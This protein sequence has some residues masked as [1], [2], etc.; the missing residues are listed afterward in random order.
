MNTNMIFVSIVE[1]SPHLSF[2]LSFLLLSLRSRFL[3]SIEQDTQNDLLEL[4]NGF[5]PQDILDTVQTN[6]SRKGKQILT[7][8][9]NIK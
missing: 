7:T 8:S 1:E 6:K 5:W 9:T 4:A 2:I 3:G